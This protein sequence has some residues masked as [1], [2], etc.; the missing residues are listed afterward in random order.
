MGG[1][2]G[3]GIVDGRKTAAGGH[4]AADMVSRWLD[5]GRAL[6]RSWPGAARMRSRMRQA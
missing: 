5:D 2:G 1:G 4:L 3:F 6:G